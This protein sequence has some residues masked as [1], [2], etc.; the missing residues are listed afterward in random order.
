MR[1]GNHHA[2]T[3]RAATPLPNRRTGPIGTAAGLGSLTPRSTRCRGFR[4][5]R[6][7]PPPA[8]RWRVESDRRPVASR[9][10]LPR[11]PTATANSTSSSQRAAWTRAQPSARACTRLRTTIA[12][13]TLP[14][15]LSTCSGSSTRHTCSGSQTWPTWRNTWRP[16]RSTT[17]PDHLRGDP[18]ALAT[19]LKRW[20]PDGPLTTNST[21]TYVVA[22]R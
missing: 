7:P 13:P 17:L 21:I 16:R 8:A 22:T 2:C 3:G 1:S 20:L 18:F 14:P 4:L 11:A 10:S 9:C 5:C 19:A 6:L 12:S 15:Q